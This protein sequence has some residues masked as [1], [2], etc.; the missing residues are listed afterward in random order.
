MKGTP[1]KPRKKRGRPTALTPRVEAR[2]LKL[3][4]EGANVVNAC[5]AVKISY[6]VL[7]L[8]DQTDAGFTQRLARAALYGAQFALAKAENRLARATPKNICV[9]REVALHWRWVAS[10][11]LPV[12]SD[13]IVHGIERMDGNAPVNLIDAARRMAFLIRAGAD[14][15]TKIERQKATLLLPAP[16]P[17]VEI[18][19][20]PDRDMNSRDEENY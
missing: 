8:R 17:S 7:V 16:R 2:L 3:I 6:A 11:L 1:T 10:K 14:E 12:Y 20:N 15:V 13:R 18:E 4:T 9:A 19:I 5:R